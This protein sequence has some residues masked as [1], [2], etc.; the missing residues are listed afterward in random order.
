MSF[1]LFVSCF[2]DGEPAS[3]ALETLEAAFRP[4]ITRSEAEHRYWQVTYSE[5]ETCGIYV[6]EDGF[7]IDRPC[8]D[9]RLWQTLFE[10]LREHPLVLFWP[11]CSRPLVGRAATIPHLAPDFT[12]ALGVPLVVASAA[13]V[14]AA[15]RA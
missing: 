8:G 12:D 15:I 1:T 6:T 7:S 2:Q 9:A 14:L 11:D 10:L 5:R 3:L 4:Y 13:E